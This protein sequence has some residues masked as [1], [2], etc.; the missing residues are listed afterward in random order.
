MLELKNLRV[1]PSYEKRGIGAKLLKSAEDYARAKGF[2]KLQGDA[3]AD[4]SKIIRFMIKHG[5]RI[6]GK[7]KLYLPSKIEVILSKEI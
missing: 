4:N 2:K 5:F 6:E 7:E 1:L 3:H